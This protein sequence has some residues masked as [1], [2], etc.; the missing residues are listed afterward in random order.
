MI[1]QRHRQTDRRMTTCDRKTALCTIVHR[2]VMGEIQQSVSSYQP[3]MSRSDITHSGT[4]M[5]SIISASTALQPEHSHRHTQQR[6]KK[7]LINNGY[8]CWSSAVHR[9]CVNKAASS[10][11]P[12]ADIRHCTSRKIYV[13]GPEGLV[14]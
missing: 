3:W 4:T 5:S 14:V 10:R 8:S 6:L 12:V 7:P 11:S 13:A 2:A 1:H 9:L